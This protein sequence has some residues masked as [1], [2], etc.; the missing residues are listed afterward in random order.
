MLVGGAIGGLSHA[1]KLASLFS[2]LAFIHCSFKQRGFLFI[3]FI[4]KCPFLFIHEVTYPYPRELGYNE[5]IT[6]V[7]EYIIAIYF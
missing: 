4:G 2:V 6:I 7:Q 3:S 5:Y 1:F